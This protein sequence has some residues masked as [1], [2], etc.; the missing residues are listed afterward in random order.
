M[1]TLGFFLVDCFFPSSDFQC[2]LLALL[3]LLLLFLFFFLRLKIS[4]EPELWA[5][6]LL[7]TLVS[8]AR[9]ELGKSTPKE[10]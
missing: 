5:R 1:T 3:F 6:I 10:T 4:K 7:I 2:N 8:T 9:N